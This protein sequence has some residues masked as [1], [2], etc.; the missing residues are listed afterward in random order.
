[1][2]KGLVVDGNNRP[3]SSEDR[4]SQALSP[5]SAGSLTS[6]VT[7]LLVGLRTLKLRSRGG[8]STSAASSLPKGVQCSI[9]NTATP[10]SCSINVSALLS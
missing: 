5:R 3:Q 2:L 1:M 7:C 9:Q 8:L 4:V 6:V 10:K